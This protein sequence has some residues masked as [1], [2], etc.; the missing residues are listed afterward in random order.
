MGAPLA[1]WIKG[2]LARTPERKTGSV[3]A[4]DFDGKARRSCR[5]KDALIE[6]I[7]IPAM[8]ASSK[9]PAFLTIRCQPEEIIW[10]YYDRPDAAV[11]GAGLGARPTRWLS[12]NFRLR[13]GELPCQHVSKVDAFTIRQ[14][15][16]ESTVNQP[17]VG[18]TK[19]PVSLEFPNIKVTLPGVDIGPWHEWFSEFVIR[20]RNDQENELQGTLEFLDPTMKE[21]IASVE[22]SQVGIFS[23]A[24]EKTGAGG[25][26]STRYVAE[27]YVESM[28]INL[29][30]D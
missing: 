7:T 21:T 12:A 23:L 3:V 29:S 26:S 1:G 15:I 30:K 13:I 22:F 16:M 19:E 27:L 9:A 28:A 8:D 25:E 2:S 6:E 14:R 5:F 4:F 24:P 18:S 20:G 10:D 17:G 11:I